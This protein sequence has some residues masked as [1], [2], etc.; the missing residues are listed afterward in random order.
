LFFLS[1]SS[2]FFFF[3]EFLADIL[4]RLLAICACQVHYSI[5]SPAI[6]IQK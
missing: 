3:G 1:F 4:S 6:Y 2:S 5:S